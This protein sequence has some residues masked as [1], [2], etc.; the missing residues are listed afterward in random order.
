[1]LSPSMIKKK[2]TKCLKK[3][4]K[5]SELLVIERSQHKKING[6]IYTCVSILLFASPNHAGQAR[7]GIQLYM[8]YTYI[9]T[10]IHTLGTCMYVCMH[11]NYILNC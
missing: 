4:C 6:E 5:L 7:Y 2:K 1:M 9:H 10:Y 11:R 3:N 8:M